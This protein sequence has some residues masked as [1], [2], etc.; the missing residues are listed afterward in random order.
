MIM[1]VLGTIDRCI[2][3]LPHELIEDKV[4]YIELDRDNYETMQE[5]VNAKYDF[6]AEQKVTDMG[7][8]LTMLYREFKIVIVL[9]KNKSKL[10]NFYVAFKTKVI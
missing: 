10:D 2:N 5:E 6:V 7:K 4:L 1:G 3:M 9:N 8:C